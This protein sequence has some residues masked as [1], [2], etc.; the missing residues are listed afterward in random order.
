MLS[1]MKM[2]MKTEAEL[3]DRILQGEWRNYA[4]LVDKYEAKVFN[5][6]NYLMSNREDAEEMVQ[7]TFIKAY[8]SLNQFRGDAAFSTWLIRIAHHNCLTHFRKKV[9]DKVSLDTVANTSFDH[10][11]NAPSQNLDSND[12]QK[13]LF[14]ALGKLKPDERATVTLFYYQ[15]LSLQEICDVTDLSLSN[16]KI[17][18]HRS[19]KK[20]LGIL[21][22][23]G[24][25]ENTL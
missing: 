25:K 19:R 20:L 15:E 18:L 17:L 13:A 2:S 8:R 21:S 14:Q 3:I 22:Q 11:T 12:R 24:I 23:M 4:I 5:Y 6:V 7:D 16:V 10:M 1:K 9:P